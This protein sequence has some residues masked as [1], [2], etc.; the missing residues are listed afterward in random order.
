MEGLTRELPTGFRTK[1]F[2]N[3][4]NPQKTIPRYEN[5]STA[6]KDEF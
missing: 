3:K 1:K 6:K 2:P 5:F 4:W